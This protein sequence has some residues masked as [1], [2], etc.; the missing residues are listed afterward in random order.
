LLRDV[1]DAAA[2]WVSIVTETNVPHIENIS[3]F[4][5]GTNEAQMVYQFA[6]PPLVVRTFQTGDARVLSGWASSLQTPS[7]STGFFNFTASQGIM[8][9]LAGVP[10]IYLHSI[11]G[12]ENWEEGVK[13]TGVAR[14]INREK[15]DVRA[16]EAEL[17]DPG[18]R[19]AQ[20][21][22]RYR[23]LLSIRRAQPAFH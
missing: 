13:L 22:R 19:R 20:V 7:D 3:Y 15:L 18:S 4:G 16:V 10:G 6:L 1:L 21:F 2:P 14:A 23:Q 9:A 5:N 8:L 12:S 17:S 11:L